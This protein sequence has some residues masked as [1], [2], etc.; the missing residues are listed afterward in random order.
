MVVVRGAHEQPVAS[1][2][3]GT[4][5]AVVVRLVVMVLEVVGVMVTQLLIPEQVVGVVLVDQLQQQVIRVL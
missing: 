1:A 3:I 2:H 4:V 5:V